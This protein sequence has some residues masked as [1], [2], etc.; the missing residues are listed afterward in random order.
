MH[1]RE[2]S[3][4]RDNRRRKIGDVIWNLRNVYRN[5]VV[6][7]IK[8]LRH[9]EIVLRINICPKINPPEMLEHSGHDGH[10]FLNTV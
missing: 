3:D 1:I 8:T 10:K 5:L 2:K 9:D 7:K 4:E 6:A